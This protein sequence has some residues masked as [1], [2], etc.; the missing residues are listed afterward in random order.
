MSFLTKGVSWQFKEST[1]TFLTKKKVQGC[2]GQKY[3]SLGSV[4][5]IYPYAKY[6]LGGGSPLLHSQLDPS[7]TTLN[8]SF[9]F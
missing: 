8:F 6:I 1:R 2:P 7:F 5:S 4:W 9:Y 3:Q